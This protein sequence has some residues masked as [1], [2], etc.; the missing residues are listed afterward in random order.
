MRPTPQIRTAN[1]K[2]FKRI[3]VPELD[4]ARIPL[5]PPG[6]SWDHENSTLIVQYKKPAAIMHVEREAKVARL[7]ANDEQPALEGDVQ[8]QCKQQ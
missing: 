3:D 7:N 8:E 6:L 4:R 2:Y 1:K 5:D